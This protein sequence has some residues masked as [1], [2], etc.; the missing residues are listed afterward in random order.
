VYVFTFD[1]DDNISMN[2]F[3]RI[4]ELAKNQDTTID[5]LLITVF[6]G[7]ITRDVYNGWRR[8]NVFHGQMMP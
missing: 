7:A 4:K 5:A 6:H 8:R 3:D 1:I 2:I